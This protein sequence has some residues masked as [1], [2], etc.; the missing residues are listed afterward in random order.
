MLTILHTES[1]T[2]WGGQENRTLHESIGLKALG[3]RIL[4]LCQPSGILGEK[5][6]TRGIEVRRC[7]MRKSYD[8]LAIKYILDLIKTE[9]IDII[10]THS[11]KDTLLAG[12]AGRL[13]ARK[14]LIV[15]TRHLALPITSRFTYRYLSHRIVTVSEYVR[16]YLIGEGIP[17]KQVTAVPTC[18]DLTKFDP[19]KTKENLREDMGVERDTPLVGTV[20]ILRRK[21]GHHILIDAIPLIL[22]KVP[23]AVF[24]FAGNGP[25]KQNIL[26][27]IK[28]LGLEN[29]VFMLGLRNDVPAI[30]KSIDLFVLPTFQEALGTSF[31]EA[32]AMGKPVVGTNVGGVG[33]VIKNGLNGFLIEPDSP[34]AVAEAIIKL[35]EDKESAKKMG[36]EGR[37]MVERNFSVEKMCREMLDLYSSLSERK[38]R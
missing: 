30:L 1:S 9:N 24:V 12:I 18:V 35:L 27:K 13:S 37:K 15:R 36:I 3:Q 20:S 28:S 32:M 23:D 38:N 6:E 4:I 5:A 22:K 29:K 8:I 25:Q 26:N 33:E 14:P 17:E 31:L 34:R 2:G 21:K 11:G 19:E 10:N 16:Q 7:R